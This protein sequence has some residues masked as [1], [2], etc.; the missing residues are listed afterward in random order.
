MDG[1]ATTV[2]RLA[3]DTVIVLDINKLSK[4]KQGYGVTLSAR[5]FE[6][7]ANLVFVDE[8]HKGQRSEESVWKEIQHVLAGIGAPSPAERGLLIE[9]SATFGQVVDA[10]HSFAR[11]AKS[12][13]FDYAYD[14]F[15]HDRY[16]KDFWHVRTNAGQI[17]AQAAQR[18]TLTAALL[19]YWY[20]R[21]CYGLTEARQQAAADGLGIVSPLW[22]LLGLSVIGATKNEADKAQTSD[23]IDVI[24]FLASIIDTPASL[25]SDASQIVTAMRGLPDGSA[26]IVPPAVYSEVQRISRRDEFA[27]HILTECFGWQAGDKF[28]LRLIKSATGELGLGLL[29]GEIVHY[30]GVINVGDTNGLAKELALHSL[31]VA[32][33]ALRRSLFAELDAPDSMLNVLIGSRRFA[34]GWDNYR[35]SSLTL[36]RLGQGEGS[37]IIQMFGRVVRFAGIH[38][39][40]KRL[41][42]PPTL[43]APLQTAY[44]YG[45]K[46]DYLSTFLKVLTENGA[47]PTEPIIC[48][49]R[50]ISIS[51]LRTIK[52]RPQPP[53]EFT[54]EL[55]GEW[56]KSVNGGTLSL[57][58]SVATA[59]LTDNGMAV[60]AGA[61]GESLTDKFRQWVP[62][63]DHDA[64]YVQMVEWRR[65]RQ[66]WNLRFDRDSVR[67]ALM[68]GRYVIEGL[69]AVMVVRDAE[70][71]ARLNRV[72][73]TVVRRIFERAYQRKRPRD[74]GLDN[75]P[76]APETYLREIPEATG[77]SAHA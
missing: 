45:L 20:Q 65:E 74:L 12:V 72:A 17:A 40:G 31:S 66:W 54:V 5:M 49:T 10:E 52:T 57:S 46:S 18:Q 71:L 27:E 56:Y 29:R 60:A 61:M 50:Q 63:L 36:L 55:R 34:E 42:Q 51:T 33:D 39:N 41:M 67:Q 47:T 35:A 26:G 11:Y 9:F 22:V 15:H 58:A 1:D 75:L 21:H 25:R 77:G 59:R 16:G 8:G 13:V 23:V 6:G 4:S 64:L 76:I 24:R 30:L 48:N 44:V 7:G 19:S 70:D 28:V 73:A 37:L 2:G 43:L 38:G 62:L 68:N 69:P 3:P 14:R 53:D 32:E